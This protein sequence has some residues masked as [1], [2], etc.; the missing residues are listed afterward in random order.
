MQKLRKII[1]TY[2]QYFPYVYNVQKNIIPMC[3]LL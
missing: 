2:Y 3:F 1:T